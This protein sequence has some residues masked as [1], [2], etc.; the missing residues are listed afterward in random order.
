MK[1]KTKVQDAWAK[2]G[3]A[4]ERLNIDLTV[5]NEPLSSIMTWLACKLS[6]KF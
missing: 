4:H 6:T 2:W 3:V 1:D 5:T